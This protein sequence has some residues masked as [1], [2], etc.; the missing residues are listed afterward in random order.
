MVGLRTNEL[1]STCDV[2]IP[3]Q[4]CG[5]SLQHDYPVG[6]EPSAM[7]IP[8]IWA[9]ANTFLFIAKKEASTVW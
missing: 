7:R 5:Q 2:D 8:E 4:G 3:G 1:G 9:S 6:D